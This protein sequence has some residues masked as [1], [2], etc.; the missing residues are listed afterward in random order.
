MLNKKFGAPDLFTLGVDLVSFLG[1]TKVDGPNAEKILR[2][3]LK[4]SFQL[5]RVKGRHR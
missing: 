2:A 5:A 3:K 1:S 4:H